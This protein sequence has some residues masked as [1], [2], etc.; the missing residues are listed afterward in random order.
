MKA[1]WQTYRFDETKDQAWVL[2]RLFITGVT[3]LL[4]GC[5]C[6]VAANWS[7]MGVALKLSLPLFMLVLCGAGVYYKT[8]D[9]LAGKGCAFGAAVAIGL[10]WAVFG[11]LY[12]SGAFLYELFGCWFLLLLPFCVLARNKWLWLMAL[13][14]G[15]AYLIS[16]EN[17]LRFSAFNQTAGLFMVAWAAAY[18]KK[19]SVVFQ[20]FI[21]VPLTVYVCM[22]GVGSLSAGR[23]VPSAYFYVAA[24]FF[25]LESVWAH[26]KKDTVLFGAAVL[27]GAV[28]LSA[29]TFRLSGWRENVFSLF[30]YA[31]YF[32][33]AGILTFFFYYFHREKTPSKTIVKTGVPFTVRALI[34]LCAF[35]GTFFFMVMLWLMR[36]PLWVEGILLA[37]AG[38][39]LLYKMTAKG[40]A[41]QS[42]LRY[43]GL[44]LALA[45][46]WALTAGAME[47]FHYKD[48]W[49][50]LSASVLFYVIFP[51]TLNR[52]AWCVAGAFACC[53]IV[54][55]FIN[56]VPAVDACIVLAFMGALCLVR[57]HRKHT[58][59][60]AYG[61]LLF[62]VFLFSEKD[63]GWMNVYGPVFLGLLLM[64][65]GHKS[66]D[67]YAEIFGILGASYGMIYLYYSLNVSL[68]YKAL[69]LLVGG[70]FCLAVR[71][72][73]AH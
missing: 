19:T 34:F 71:R 58:Y 73:Y 72:I 38:W 1:I 36:V 11:Q 41:G 48:E 33:A 16:K 14:V 44:V 46:Q 17:V 40:P 12:P 10:F 29:F 67:R 32:V 56:F 70:L 39:L 49:V 69:T 51:H 20:R 6:F 65:A 66:A 42:F 26:L 7:S 8:L 63:L 18:Y 5:I 60:V 52:L 47:F 2:L 30:V 15:G 28:L 4:A 24:V 3:F 68:S 37:S 55:E 62:C 59:P 54:K 53:V 25:L 35:I 27:G 31:V 9:T 50:I 64:Y 57:I 21:W 13:Y 45:G 23:T 61:L 22:H 43:L